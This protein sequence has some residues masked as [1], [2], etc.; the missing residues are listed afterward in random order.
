MTVRSPWLPSACRLIVAAATLGSLAEVANGQ[1]ATL[2]SPWDAPVVA[3]HATSFQCPAPPQ[4]PSSIAAADYYSDPAHS[5]IDPTRKRAYDDATKHLRSTLRTVIDMADEYRSQ[6]N[7]A[8][9]A[10]AAR[11]LDSFAAN[12]ALAGTV[13]TNQATYVQGWIL[14]SFAVAWLKIRADD[15]LPTPQ[16]LKITGWF[17]DIAARNIAYYAPRSLEN[18]GRNN[19]R[20]WAGFMAMAAGI[21]AD[22]K[23]LFDWG[24]DSFKIG[25]KQIQPDGTLPLE[26]DRRKRALHYHIFAAAP[27]VAMAEMASANGID[28]YALDNG[29]L[30][31]LV[32]RDVAGIEDPSYFTVKAGA[33]QDP[34]Q[35]HVEDIS[36]AVPFERRFP[37]PAL[38]ALLKAVP[39]QSML[40]L[41][42]LPAP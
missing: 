28:L 32:E 27:L 17:A 1:P 25:A 21:A 15:R 24:A 18:D 40:Y 9:A 19:H 12:N 3:N 39:S 29:A 41:G 8:A 36:W 33:M 7:E 35:L 13:T 14:G 6:G 30:R 31:R 10:C 5:V 20:Y 22:R 16:R 23:D 42:G 26:M 37:E 4:L 2:H 11:F 38:A 34:V